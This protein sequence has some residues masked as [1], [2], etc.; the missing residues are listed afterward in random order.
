[1]PNDGMVRPGLLVSQDNLPFGEITRLGGGWTAQT[2]TLLAPLTAVPTTVAA[3]ELWNNTTSGMNMVI[4]DVFADMILGTAAA[5]A[6][7]IYACVL[8]SKAVPTLTALTVN[9]LSGRAAYTSAA[10]SRVVTGVGT[11]VIAAGWRPWGNPMAWGTAAATPGPS[12]N[13]AVDGK[14]IVPPGSSLALHIVGSLTTASSFQVGASW[15]EV[16][17]TTYPAVA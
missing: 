3:L 8:V 9:S 17:N 15:Y 13:A 7:A 1:M 4:S 16:S 14:L 6:F 2:A 10:G 11:T 12:W 5:Q